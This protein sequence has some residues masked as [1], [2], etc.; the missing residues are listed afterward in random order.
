VL[1][2]DRARHRIP[3]RPLITAVG[4]ATIRFTQRAGAFT[5]PSR[6]VPNTF[7]D[8]W[9]DRSSISGRA[10]APA[11]RARTDHA[12]GARLPAATRARPAARRRSGPLLGSGAGAASRAGYRAAQ[13]AGAG[14]RT[15]TRGARCQPAIALDLRRATRP[16]RGAGGRARAAGA[17]RRPAP[18][19]STAAAGDHPG[20]AARTRGRLAALH[21]RRRGRSSRKRPDRAGSARTPRRFN[22]AELAMIV[23][24][25]PARSSGRAART[26]RLTR[27][28]NASPRGLAGTRTS[29]PSSPGQAGA[30]HLGARSV[31]KPQ[32]F[33]GETRGIETDAQAPITARCS[34]YPQGAGMMRSACH[35]EG[36]GFESHQPLS[37]KPCICGAF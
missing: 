1:R 24:P 30:Q 13:A 12:A 21:T 28:T 6:L 2:D 35:A 5:R 27:C 23:T 18:G 33:P 31:P 3:L 25:R 34:G 37:K 15:R 32:W 36:R 7:G 11:D 26:L 17:R 8:G 9:R 4:G 20:R 22:R 10:T 29:P 19:S 16:R 14:G